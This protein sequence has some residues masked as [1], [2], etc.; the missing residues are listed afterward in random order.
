MVRIHP[1]PPTR[2][3]SKEASFVMVGRVAC[4]CKAGDK[5]F[6]FANHRSMLTA[7]EERCK[8][9]HLQKSSAEDI[10]SKSTIY[11]CARNFRIVI[12]NICWRRR[13]GLNCVIKRMPSLSTRKETSFVYQGKRG[14]LLRL[15]CEYD[16][17]TASNCMETEINN[18]TNNFAEDRYC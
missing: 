15:L 10:A 1:S 12:N 18:G 16:I 11:Y 17:I 5:H 6:V 14:F 7:S 13:E 9:L 2:D 4:P 8:R 3:A